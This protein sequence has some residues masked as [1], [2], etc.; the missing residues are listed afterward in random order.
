MMTMMTM[1]MAEEE[2]VAVA[3]VEVEMPAETP[4]TMVPNGMVLS[5]LRLLQRHQQLL[6]VTKNQR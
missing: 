6:H 4:Q 1:M 2:T 3:M 5:L